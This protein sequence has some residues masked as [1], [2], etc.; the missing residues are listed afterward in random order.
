MKRVMTSDHVTVIVVVVV[1]VAVVVVVVVG[2]PVLT[3]DEHRMLTT[4][5]PT[6]NRKNLDVGQT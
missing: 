3:A 4:I 5:H 1:V 2:D 6:V